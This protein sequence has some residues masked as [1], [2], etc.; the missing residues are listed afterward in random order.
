MLHKLKTYLRHNKD[1]DALWTC[2]LYSPQEFN[3]LLRRERL[4][5]N[6]SHDE[7]SVLRF[8]ARESGSRDLTLECLVSLLQ[9]RLRCTDDI[10]WLQKGIIG[11]LLPCTPSEDAARVADD[12]YVAFPSDVTPPHCE[13][14]SYPT[15]WPNTLQIGENHSA[16]DETGSLHPVKA[17]EQLL[18]R[19]LPLWKRVLDIVGAS[20]GIAM[21]IPLLV[22]IVICIKTFMRGP[23]FFKQRRIGLG[24]RPFWMYKFR[25]MVTDAEQLREQLLPL[26]EQ[27]GPAFKIENDPR[28]TR[29]GRFL[30][31]SSL[32]ELPQLW[33]VLL[34]NMSLVG[35]RPL[36]V[37]ESDGCTRWQRERLDVTP[38]LTCIWQV[39]GRSEV[40]FDTWMRM[41]LQYARKRS[42]RYDLKLLLL[43][44]PAVLRRK[45]A[46]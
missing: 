3:T 41:D 34:G 35:P 14:Y 16:M 8:A 40:S 39:R 20:V 2:D 36:P 32:D 22:C 11:V 19:P 7:F 33:N 30:R 10:G 28:V 27:D 29:V 24:G 5:V 17:M 31:R 15:H 6:R 4:R 13:I 21:A 23:V 46:K 18:C 37:H 44:I 26:N 38:G 25:T 43:T 12:I 42:P 45:G 9:R 1:V